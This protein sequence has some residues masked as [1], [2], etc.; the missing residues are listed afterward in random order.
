[1]ENKLIELL[2]AIVKIIFRT[3]LVYCGCLLFIGIFNPLQWELTSKI[4]FLVIT[5]ILLAQD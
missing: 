2:I 5:I 3:G 4:L 1:M